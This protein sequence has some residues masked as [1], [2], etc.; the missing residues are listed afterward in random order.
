MEPIDE[1]KYTIEE[2]KQI[3][4]KMVKEETDK[5][6]ELGVTD[7]KFGQYEKTNCTLVTITTTNTIHKIVFGKMTKQV[8]LMASF[9][10]CATCNMK[11]LNVYKIPD[12]IVKFLQKTT[13]TG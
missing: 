9:D 11:E 10:G 4:A 6:P 2:L 3:A 1:T 12:V 5:Y 8:L 7:V 13:Q